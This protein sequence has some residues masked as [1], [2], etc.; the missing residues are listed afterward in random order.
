MSLKTRVTKLE[1]KTPNDE[2]I[3]VMGVRMKHSFLVATIKSAEGTA[4][5]PACLREGALDE[6]A[7]TN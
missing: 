7:H 1:S 6:S 5:L 2:W 3:E 4:L